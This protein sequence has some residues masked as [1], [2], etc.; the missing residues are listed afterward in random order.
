[1][2]LKKD[3]ERHTVEKFQFKSATGQTHR[4]YNH[5]S[6]RQK[7]TVIGIYG[8]LRKAKALSDASWKTFVNFRMQNSIEKYT[9]CGGHLTDEE[10]NVTGSQ[11][12][13]LS[14]TTTT[15]QLSLARQSLKRKIDARKRGSVAKWS[16]HNTSNDLSSTQ[17]STPEPANEEINYQVIFEQVC[18]TCGAKITSSVNLYERSNHCLTHIHSS[19]T[20]REAGRRYNLSLDGIAISNDLQSILRA[21]EFK[22]NAAMYQTELTEIT[23]ALDAARQRLMVAEQRTNQLSAENREL[24]AERDHLVN[25]INARDEYEFDQPIGRP[26][27]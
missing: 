5:I 1:M 20:T 12:T 22:R 7:L 19:C 3:V 8:A 21:T 14:E 16:S 13:N 15:S 24:K 9:M 6:M 25:Q 26:E 2:L 23:R 18:L 27:H 17:D 10:D 11:S 4:C